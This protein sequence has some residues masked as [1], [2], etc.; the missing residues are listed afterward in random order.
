[1]EI[2]NLWRRIRRGFGERVLR[3]AS[4]ASDIEGFCNAFEQE[5]RVLGTERLKERY[6][7]RFTIWTLDHPSPQ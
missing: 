1:M 5:K 2:R 6:E 7:E 4:R 3:H